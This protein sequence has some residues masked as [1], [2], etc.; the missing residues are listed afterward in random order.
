MNLSA[1][2]QYVE[3]SVFDESMEVIST[4][5]LVMPVPDLVFSKWEICSTFVCQL[6]DKGGR[7]YNTVLNYRRMANGTEDIRFW[8]GD[9][10]LEGCPP[11]A[12][13]LSAVTKILGTDPSRNAGDA[14]KYLEYHGKLPPSTRCN[15]WL[16][17]RREKAVCS[18][19]SHMLASLR[20]SR[21]QF[22]EELR[23][24]YD[25]TVPTPVV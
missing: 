4:E 11:R 2:T 10:F 22:V 25:S 16:N 13:V 5:L 24:L 19:V 20:T 3:K 12:Q 1:I 18:H 23:Q 21:P 14:E 6:K 15:F 8:C 17:W 7:L 9:K